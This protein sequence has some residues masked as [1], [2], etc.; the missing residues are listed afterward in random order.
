MTVPYGTPNRRRYACCHVSSVFAAVV[1][2]DVP[3]VLPVVPPGDP[4][5]PVPVPVV[6]G[7]GVGVFTFASRP[8]DACVSVLS[9][10]CCPAICPSI[11]VRSSELPAEPASIDPPG[12]DP[13][14]W[15]TCGVELPPR[16]NL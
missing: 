15:T 7:A 2:P 14:T 4:V 8:V 13:V 12:C 16:T 9:W 5:T 6:D 1:P 10:P 3:V 11:A